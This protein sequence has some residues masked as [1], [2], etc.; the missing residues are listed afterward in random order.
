MDAGTIKDKL[1]TIFQD[2]MD[3]DDIV[4]SND[5]T[6]DEIEGWDS[7]THVRLIVAIEQAFSIKFTNAEI[8][9][10][11]CVGDLIGAIQQRNL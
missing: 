9:G 4:I 3:I 6:A 8:Y 7:L 5:T 10:F 1:N 2:V 11:K